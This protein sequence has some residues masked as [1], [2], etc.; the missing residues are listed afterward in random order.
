MRDIK[1]R[2][3]GPATIVASLM[4][5]LTG[6]GIG[7]ESA[8][9]TP[10]ASASPTEQ[11]AIQI[12][13]EDLAG[14]VLFHS[15][16][17][18]PF[19]TVHDAETGNQKTQIDLSDIFEPGTYW[20]NIAGAF[21]LSPDLRYATFA[22]QSGIHLGKLDDTTY[23]YRETALLTPEKGSSFSGGKIKFEYPQFTPDASQLW[24][25]QT[26]TKGENPE[27]VFSIDTEDPSGSK[28]RNIG[29]TPKDLV[30]KRAEEDFGAP[31][32]AV[33][34]NNEFQEQKKVEAPE[35]SPRGLEYYETESGVAPITFRSDGQGGYYG[36][37]RDTTSEEFPPG[38][39]HFKLSKTGEIKDSEK[40][41]DDEERR[42]SNIWVDHERSRLL[43]EA[44][45]SYYQARFGQTGE[46]EP[47]F[48]EFTFENEETKWSNMMDGV[49][50]FFPPHSS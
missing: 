11:E 18:S 5:T 31:L 42:I 15:D 28:P 38:L 44:D 14:F 4:L 34:P 12:P 22:S 3:G 36:T 26:E 19:I 27:K 13:A 9:D 29:E 39:Y 24:V 23:T 30:R 32:Y 37:T 7:S 43:I 1:T 49:I 25:L 20:G 10:P 33:G 40:I 48:S 41:V 17:E 50:G 6:C 45:H 46:P 16:S 8:G 35:N 2:L 47:L 21:T